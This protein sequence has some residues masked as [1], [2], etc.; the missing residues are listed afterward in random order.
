MKRIL[1]LGLLSLFFQ[2]ECLTNVLTFGS[3]KVE[4]LFDAK[5]DKEN[6]RDEEDWSLLAR[7][8]SGKKEA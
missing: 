2:W 8:A 5:H 1:F 4:N 7:E 3:Y 6:G